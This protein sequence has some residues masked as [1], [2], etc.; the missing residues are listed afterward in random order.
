[1][2]D[3]NQLAGKGPFDGIVRANTQKGKFFYRLDLKFSGQAAKSFAKTI[4]G[5][6]AEIDLSGTA[7]PAD[8]DIPIQ[9]KDKSQRDIILRRPFSF[10]DCLT[11][12]DKTIAEI[13]YCVVGPATLRMTTLKPGDKVS[14][15]GPLGN[16]FSVP[17]GKTIAILTAGG[18]GSPP[19][20]HLAN[21][22]S[23]NYPDI[24]IVAIAGAKSKE[25]MPFDPKQFAKCEI[26]SLITTDDGSEGLSGFVTVHLEER[27]KN[28]EV[29]KEQIIIYACGPEVMLS[30]VAKIAKSK[31]ID[32]QVSMERRMACGIGLCQGCAVECKAEDVKETIY[33]L[34]CK[35]G[36]VFDASNIIFNS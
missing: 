26:E 8:I 11:D 5:Q 34:C 21:V 31:G 22:L 32:C 10:C 1:M 9:L 15:I 23:K 35:D 6:F 2:T 25:E 14:L 28:I 17:V 36:P 18:M 13:L 4:P 27:L 3:Q 7:L 24:H 20:Q 19:V 29:P 30:A 12:G 33:K 16:G